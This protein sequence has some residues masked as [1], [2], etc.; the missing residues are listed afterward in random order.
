MEILFFSQLLDIVLAMKQ[1]KQA[2]GENIGHLLYIYI[3]I[4][5]V[6]AMNFS[7]QMTIGILS[8]GTDIQV[9]VFV[10]SQNSFLEVYLLN[11]NDLYSESQTSL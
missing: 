11:F 3:K 6:R 7:L 1:L 10:L 9:I 4:I 5:H 8:T 2:I